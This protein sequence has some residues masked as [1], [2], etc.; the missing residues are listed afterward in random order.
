MIRYFRNQEIDKSQWDACISGSQLPM[1]YGCSWYL[2]VVSPGWDAL[3][4][5][6][7]RAVMPL[8]HAHKFFIG[9]LYQPF[10]T[11][12]LGVFTLTEPGPGVLN[13]FMDAIPGRFRFIDIQLNE[14]NKSIEHVIARKN[15]LLI[16]EPGYEKISGNYDAHTKRKLK[17]VKGNPGVCSPEELVRFFRL[18][19]AADVQGVD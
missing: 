1:V 4:L 10:F 17:K 14:S 11:Q 12:Q 15:Y 7:Y 9:Y 6:D 5:D 13:D 18:H 8:T 19:K 2:D 3:V 16:L